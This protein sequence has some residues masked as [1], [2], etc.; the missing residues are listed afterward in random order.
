MSVSPPPSPQPVRIC[1]VGT[2][3]DDPDTLAA[4]QTFSVPVITSETGA[5]I[6]SDTNW[7]TY[8]IMNEFDG[9]IFKAI[10]KT[11][12]RFVINFNFT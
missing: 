10:Q 9:P 8:F 4:A 3:V 1:L 5:E 2:V 6:L 12:H 11:K 7:E